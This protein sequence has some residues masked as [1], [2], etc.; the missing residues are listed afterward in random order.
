MLTDTLSSVCD[1]LYFPQSLTISSSATIKQ[2]RIALADFAA[3][4][5]RAGTID[6]LRKPVLIGFLKWLKAQGLAARTANERTGR[7]RALWRWLAEEELIDR[8]PPK[9]IRLPVPESEPV[10]WTEDEL[11]LLYLAAITMPGQVAGINAGDWW[12]ALLV[13]LWNTGE[14]YGA[15]MALTWPM[16]D[17][18]KRVAIISP[19]ARKGRRKAAYYRLWPDTL[20]HLERIRTASPRVFPWSKCDCTYWLD[21]GRLSKRA[22]LPTGRN[23]KTQSMR[24]SHATWLAVRGGDATRSLMH[25]DPATTRKHYIDSRLTV[26]EPQLFRLDGG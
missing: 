19:D 2:Y 26:A 5:G 24:V 21:W 6:D 9:G 22:G 10:A 17:E 23:R 16:I 4:I 18:K 14:R 25:S 13:W 12:Q 11:R 1:T 8:V 7:I 3:F 20:E 15:T